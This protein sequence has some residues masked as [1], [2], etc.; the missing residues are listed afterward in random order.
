MMLNYPIGIDIGS[1]TIKILIPKKA[2]Q[3]HTIK[4]AIIL[5]VPE[6]DKRRSRYK[7]IVD[8]L[9]DVVRD[10]HLQKQK[11]FIS[12]SGEGVL[13]QHD[14]FPEMKHDDMVEAIRWKF[15]DQL[16][17][18]AEDAV[19]DFVVSRE[20]YEDNQ[21]QVELFVAIISKDLIER[22]IDIIQSAGL[23]PVL[24]NFTPFACFEFYQRYLAR[25]SSG[26]STVLWLEAGSSFSTL[27]VIKDQ[28]LDFARLINFGTQNLTTALERIPV[29]LFVN[30]AEKGAEKERATTALG[31]KT[32]EAA[33]AEPPVVDLPLPESIQGLT[34][35]Q[36]RLLSTDFTG[37][38]SIGLRNEMDNLIQEVIR[39]LAYYKEKYGLNTVDRVII[40][41]GLGELRGV[42]QYLSQELKLPVEKVDL[43]TY[44][45]CAPNVRALC[46]SASSRL[47]SLVGLT[48]MSPR[49]S[50]NFITKK[51]K[52]SLELIQI[53]IPSITTLAATAL[54]LFAVW[55]LVNGQLVNSQKK[56]DQSQKELKSVQAL[57][58][59]MT[60]SQNKK[61]IDGRKISFV[62]SALK[63]DITFTR[64]LGEVSESIPDAVV[65]DE[66]TTTLYKPPTKGVPLRAYSIKGATT[67]VAA[68]ELADFIIS[69]NKSSIVK[70]ISLVYLSKRRSRSSTQQKFELLCF[71]NY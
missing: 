50:L 12:F 14:V 39:S 70:D 16:N 3:K 38:I 59:Q 15:K 60:D 11:A 33:N 35:N 56:L 47:V 46:E 53:R 8:M 25:L 45:D 62:Q 19:I 24:I 37:S 22:H 31:I 44:I 30:I 41:G 63:K 6:I 43:L 9:K 10:N 69:L 57:A 7:V 42:D 64:F 26:S 67:G 49:T 68:S 48:L 55:N 2:G 58:K 66:I 65:L 29:N 71:L 27:T 20:S 34:P 1:E 13:Y 54:F 51:V 36:T 5:P 23:T 32:E 4:N 18:P 21:K 61:N 17:F 52:E 28:Q 40:S